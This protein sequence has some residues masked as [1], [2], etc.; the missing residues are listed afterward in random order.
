MLFRSGQYPEK[1]LHHKAVQF[2]QARGYEKYFCHGI[3]HY[4]GL[5]VHDVGDYNVPL[6][7][8]MVFTIEPGLYIAAENIGV[9][10]E[11]DYIM[12]DDG[13]VCLSYDLPKDI[14]AVEQAMRAE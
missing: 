7:P 4:L 10:I 3:G 1:S 2:L 12:A 6:E 5:D 8:G 11:D 13:A 9:R 14:D